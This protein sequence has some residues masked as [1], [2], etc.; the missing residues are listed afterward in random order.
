MHTTSSTKTTSSMRAML[1]PI[2]LP[3]MIE[4]T[5]FSVLEGMLVVGT[6]N[7]GVKSQV[8]FDPSSSLRRSEPLCLCVHNVYYPVIQ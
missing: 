6:S 1:N 2:T 8:G 7:T 3:A 4:A 5:P